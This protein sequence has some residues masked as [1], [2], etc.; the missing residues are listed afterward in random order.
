VCSL[1]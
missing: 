1:V